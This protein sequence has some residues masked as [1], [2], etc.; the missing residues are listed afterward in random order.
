MTKDYRGEAEL[1][2]LQ[3]KAAA[4]AGLGEETCPFRNATDGAEQDELIARIHWRDGWALATFARLLQARKTQRAHLVAAL[5]RLLALEN[6]YGLY[7][8]TVK[9]GWWPNPFRH[10]RTVKGL[11]ALRRQIFDSPDYRL[12]HALGIEVY[13]PL[14]GDG[15][16]DL[17][18]HDRVLDVFSKKGSEETIRKLVERYGDAHGVRATWQAYVSAESIKALVAE[19][20]ATEAVQVH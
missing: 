2:F 19:A 10:W 7:L 11:A 17:A 20:G 14:P 4:E 15:Y 9:L 18:V 8:A 3:G 1:L 5:T 13:A 16:S 6:R 12:L